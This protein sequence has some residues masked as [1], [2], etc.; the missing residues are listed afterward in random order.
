MVTKKGKKKLYKLKYKAGNVAK[1]DFE[2]KDT[3]KGADGSVVAVISGVG[4]FTGT[5][6]INA[7]VK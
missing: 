6:S 4:N 3:V 2:V 5:V 7:V 1:S